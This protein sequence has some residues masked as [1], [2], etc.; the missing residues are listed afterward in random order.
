MQI[1]CSLVC[2]S[3]VEMAIHCLGSLKRLCSVPIRFRIH[4]D[5]SLTDDDV[6]RLIDLGSTEVVL[7]KEADEAMEQ[8]L[9]SLPACREY[10]R[11]HPL[12]LKL[13]DTVLMN[14][15][16]SYAFADSDVL[17]FR[18][19]EN[20]FARV[21]DFPSA[22]FMSDREN[23]YCFRSWGYLL[24]GI[25]LPA[26]INTGLVSFDRRHFD[27][28]R[29][30]RFLSL[31][32]VHAIPSMREQTCWAMLGGTTGC[33]ILDPAQLRV[34][35][36]GED[37]SELVGGHFTARTRSLLPDYVRRS[38]AASLSDAAVTLRSIPAGKC[39]A[40]DLALFELRRLIVRATGR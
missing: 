22:I 25:T 35:R 13:L 3:H 39:R 17:F 32:S 23:S 30:E 14:K 18:R 1:V 24:S 29:I 33:R 7:R 9:R 2:H 16:D 31:A 19:F 21:A 12:A 27:L 5:G 11:S 36:S 6:Q 28:N 4:D 20:P 40:I 37:E 34:M 10:R 26:S 8:Q 15:S 38:E